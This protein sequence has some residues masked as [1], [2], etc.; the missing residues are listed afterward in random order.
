MPRSEKALNYSGPSRF[1]VYSDLG[2]LEEEVIELRGKLVSFQCNQNVTK[3]IQKDRK[4]QK[5]SERIER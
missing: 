5:I 2:I 4:R 1:Y 3:Y